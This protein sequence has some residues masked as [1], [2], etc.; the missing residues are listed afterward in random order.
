MQPLIMTYGQFTPQI[1]ASAYVAPGAVLIGDVTIA[2]RAGVYFNCV[3]RGDIN[4]IAVGEGSNIQD[5]SVLH[6][7]DGYPCIVGSEVT[8]GHN[9]ILHGCVVE[10]GCL[11]GM[12][13]VVL[14]G[15]VI[16]RGSIVAAGA[17]VPERMVVPPGSLVAGVPGAVK[18]QIPKATSDSLAYW[19][20]K[21]QKVARAFITGRPFRP[22]MNL[23]P[24]E[25]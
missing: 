2:A 6:V 14:T 4:H 20:Q 21:Y 8:V 10:D 13:S 11:I 22:N 24:D 1:D 12:G 18:K 9:A 17:V 5:L 3:L 7:D 19:A 16:G 25:E 15:A 23:E